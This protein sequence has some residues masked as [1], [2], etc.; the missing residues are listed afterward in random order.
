M[1][2]NSAS[3]AAVA[4]KPRG[5]VYVREEWCKG[6]RFCIEFC[7][8]HVL[9]AGDELNARGYHPPVL[10]DAERCTGCNL[11]GMVCPDFAIWA[12]RLSS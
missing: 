2:T 7:P 6:C 4:R 12:T 9:V 8:V 10:I 1:D 3:K 5:R 11:C